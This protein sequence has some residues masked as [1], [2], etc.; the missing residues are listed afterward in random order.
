M[1][2]KTSWRSR[3]CSQIGL[4]KVASFPHGDLD[5]LLRMS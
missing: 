1:P 3:S 2:E 4:V 5:E